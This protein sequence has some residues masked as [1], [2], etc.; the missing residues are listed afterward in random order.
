NLPKLTEVP[1]GAARAGY[2][3]TY[4]S[5]NAAS[6]ETK[7]MTEKEYRHQQGRE[8]ES[9]EI[10]GEPTSVLVKKGYQ[11]AIP[12]LNITDAEGN[13]V[14][15]Q[16][17]Q[18]PY[19]NFIVVSTDVTKLSPLDYVAFDKINQTIREISAEENIR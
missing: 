14:T 10:V 19:F 7:Q 5:Q 3:L 1:E 12:D 8:D 4:T 17:I 6:A 9:W 2:E 13:Q 11:L 18:N 15:E 16:I